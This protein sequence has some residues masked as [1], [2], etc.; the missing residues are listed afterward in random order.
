MPVYEYKNA[1]TGDCFQV[2]QSIKDN[3]FSTMKELLDHVEANEDGA[4]F[5]FVGNEVKPENEEIDEGS[6][7][8]DTPVERQLFLTPVHYK[9]MGWPSANARNFKYSGK[10]KKLYSNI[11]EER[12]KR[13]S[14]GWSPADA[15][16]KIGIGGKV[17]DQRTGDMKDWSAK[18][19]VVPDAQW[20]TLPKEKQK[21][22]REHGFRPSRDWSK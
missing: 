15:A 7:E 18:D 8:D 19:S 9:G 3:R 11:R 10:H 13:R 16:Q 4:E 1:K 6:Y 14:R 2:R 12:A 22:A 20:N 17:Q 21:V 5:E